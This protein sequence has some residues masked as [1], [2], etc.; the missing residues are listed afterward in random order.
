M[1][2]RVLS[3]TEDPRL[4]SALANQAFLGRTFA[5]SGAVDAA[6]E[7]LTTGD[8]N[9]VLRKYFKPNEMAYAF[10]GDFDKKQP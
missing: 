1:Q 6:I 5:T 10:A 2:E 8:V 9:A 7:K 3:R 4:A